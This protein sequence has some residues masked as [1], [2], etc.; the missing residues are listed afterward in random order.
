MH[1]W[2]VEQWRDGEKIRKME[3]TDEMVQ[4]RE[5]GTV[6]ITFPPHELAGGLVVSMND[7]LHLREI[8]DSGES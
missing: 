3:L 4:Q 7:E 5:D 1:K 8:D 2:L 6:V